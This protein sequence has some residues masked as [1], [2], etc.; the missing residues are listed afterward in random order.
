MVKGHFS[1][2][3]FLQPLINVLPDPTPLAA[4][5][6]ISTLPRPAPAVHAFLRGAFSPFSVLDKQTGG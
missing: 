3:N 5:L 1:F 6:S 4:L 2:G